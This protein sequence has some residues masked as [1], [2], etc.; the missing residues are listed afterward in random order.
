MIKS[1]F[2]IIVISIIHNIYCADG[3][4]YITKYFIGKIA[5]Y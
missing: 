5:N 1:V 2:I 4:L 3:I